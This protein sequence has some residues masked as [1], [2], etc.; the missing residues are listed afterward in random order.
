MAAGRPSGCCII[1]LNNEKAFV[2][3]PTAQCTKPCC[4]RCPP[5][6]CQQVVQDGGVVRGQASQI[7]VGMTEHVDGGGRI[8]CGADVCTAGTGATAR[9]ATW[10]M[11]WAAVAAFS[12]AA[13]PAAAGLL[14]PMVSSFA[15]VN[16]YM[17]SSDTLPGKF[18]G[19]WWPFK[20]RLQ[21]GTRPGRPWLGCESQLSQHVGQYSTRSW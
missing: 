6:D 18:C 21:D 20:K 5:V 12:A 8:R 16:V 17:T 7:E 1:P 11:G 9:G 4:P 15:S 14:L 19:I 13:P 10:L 2:L 3:V